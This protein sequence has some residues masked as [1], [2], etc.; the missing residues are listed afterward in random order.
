MSVRARVL[1]VVLGYPIA[2]MLV[3][4]LVAHWVGW[5]WVFVAF[6]AG[7]GIGL[8][9]MRH[10]ARVTGRSWAA[11]LSGLS[12]TGEQGQPLALESNRPVRPAVPPA[13]ALLL[14][15]AGMLIAVPGFLTD[16]A[17]LVLVLPP[18]RQRIAA[19]MERR[20]RGWNR[21]TDEP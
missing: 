16:I 18:V 6:L 2:E 5:W 3:A 9:L 21:M 1:A 11:A 20:A 13:Q 14:V 7:L 17:G 12:A 10:A 8:L 4:F 19:R 15:P